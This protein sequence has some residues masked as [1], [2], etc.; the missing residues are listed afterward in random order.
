MPKVDFAETEIKSREILKLLV[1]SDSCSLFLGKD[2]EG[3]ITTLGRGGSDITAFLM[4]HCLQAEEVIVYR[5][6]RGDV[7]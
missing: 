4:G 2:M 1:R 7:Y 3:N 5:C 6:R